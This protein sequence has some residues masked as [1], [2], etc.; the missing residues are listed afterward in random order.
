MICFALYLL[1]G[2]TKT[3]FQVHGEVGSRAHENLHHWR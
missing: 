2:M 3:P 1:F